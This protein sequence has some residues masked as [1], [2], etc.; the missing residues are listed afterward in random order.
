MLYREEGISI[1]KIANGWSVIIP[2]RVKPLDTFNRIEEYRLQA[3][4]M[5][6]EILKDNELEAAQNAIDGDQEQQL[7]INI[8]AITAKGVHMF[9]TFKEVLSFLDAMVTE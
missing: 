4:A 2:V 3:R 6:E 8:D 9:K 1:N 7:E 5:R